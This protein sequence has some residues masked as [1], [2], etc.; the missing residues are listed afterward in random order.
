[1]EVLIRLPSAVPRSIW[2]CHRCVTQGPRTSRPWPAPVNKS[3]SRSNQRA[4]SRPLHTSSALGEQS[5]GSS[6]AQPLGD[7]Y[8]D[9]LSTPV[10]KS[11]NNTADDE[12]DLPTFVR[13]G[14]ETKEE[15]AR[16]LFGNIHGSGYERRSERPEAVWQT[17]NGVP[18]PPRPAEPDNCCMSGCVHCVWDDYRDDIEEWA[19]R[20]HE[21]QAK[22][23]NTSNMSTPKVDLSRPEVGSASGS[24][25]DDGGGSEALWTAPGPGQSEA[26]A[27]FAGV[28]V[29][30]REFMATEKRIRDRKKRRK[31]ARK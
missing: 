12:D 9:L 2:V 30:I 14:D 15:R 1:M 25:D 11:A 6:Q 22:A 24:M 5:H 29:G 4:P 7:F 23:T 27:L 26:D 19:G 28:P 3:P 17:I 16:K 18:V 13:S 8:Q 10:P 20:L 21:A 31:E